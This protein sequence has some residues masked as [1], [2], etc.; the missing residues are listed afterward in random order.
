M[1]VKKFIGKTNYDAMLQVKE[2]FGSEAIVLTTREVR[3]EGFLGFFKKP[4]IEITAAYDDSKTEDDFKNDYK[5][6]KLAG[7]VR[8]L[9]NMIAVMEKQNVKIEN[10]YL[11][12]YSEVL[13]N[14]GVEKN[15]AD[16]I[17]YE[18]N[19]ELKNIQTEDKDYIEG[20]IRQRLLDILGKPQPIKIVGKGNIVFFIGPTGVGKTTTIAK[21]A[22]KLVIE[23]HYEVGI[24][25]QDTYRIAAVEQLKTYCDILSLPM[26]VA[27]DADEV[28]NYCTQFGDKS[29]IFVDTAGRSHKDEGQTDELKDLILRFPDAQ[30]FLVL[31]ATFSPKVLEKTLEKYLFL[32]DFG[33]IITK[34]DEAEGLGNVVNLVKKSKKQLSYFT[35]GQNVPDDIMLAGADIV[36]NDILEGYNE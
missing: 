34:I 12:K 5:L 33:L 22:A 26:E 15:I 23:E 13:R 10:Q 27:Y 9:K 6:S 19:A 16:E 17:V 3:Q 20:L 2:E 35:D 28:E 11:L 25:T 21:L 8:S 14:S 7:E 4:L 18:I 29:L 24:V 36:I 32:S 30:I 1:K 31:N